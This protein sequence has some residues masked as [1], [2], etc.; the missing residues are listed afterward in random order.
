MKKIFLNRKRNG[1]LLA[2][3]SRYNA[4]KQ[5]LIQ[6]ADGNTK[7]VLNALSLSRPW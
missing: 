3:H 5:R 6:A 2:D 7:Q 1:R 4:T